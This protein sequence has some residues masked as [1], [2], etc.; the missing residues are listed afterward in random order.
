MIRGLSIVPAGQA[1]GFL[2]SSSVLL[3]GGLGFTSIFL[4]RNGVGT[5]VIGVYGYDG[6]AFFGSVRVVSLFVSSVLFGQG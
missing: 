1:W 5:G 4:F 6:R 3:D 2:L